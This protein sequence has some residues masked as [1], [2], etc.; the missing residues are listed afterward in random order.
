MRRHIRTTYLTPV[1]LVLQNQQA[2]ALYNEAQQAM[3]QDDFETARRKLKQANQVDPQVICR[4]VSA[5]HSSC[6]L[7]LL[8]S[9][10]TTAPQHRT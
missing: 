8:Q 10:Q 5:F 7:L 4:T 3:S 1:W 9:A 2:L 6:Q